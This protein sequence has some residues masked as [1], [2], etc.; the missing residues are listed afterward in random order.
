[1]TDKLKKAYILNICL[2]A[3]EVFAIGWMMS[4]LSA[5]V[6]SAGRLSTLK[7]FTVDSN[8][9][10]GIFALIAAL[11]QGKVLRGKKGE[12]SAW[13]YVLKLVGTVG[14]TLTM[15][16]TIF[17]LGP[18]LGR[19]YGFFSL[20]EK[21]NFFL[22]LAN[23]VLGIIVFLC[24][25]KSTKIAFRHT[26]TGIIPMVLYGIYYVSE[27]VRH[28]ENGVIA[29][30]YDWYGFFFLGIKSA[31]IVLPILVI[32]TWLISAV[33]WKLNRSKVL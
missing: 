29:K 9:L 12:V 7:Y 32:I 26:F 22:H 3:L 33:L 1:M 16:V 10:M 30:G 27:T 15:L 11:D 5:G 23:P 13:T 21:S 28:M 14:V 20:F 25:E 17:F 24:F 8:I 6:L 19:T 2:F 4:G 31:F 18:T